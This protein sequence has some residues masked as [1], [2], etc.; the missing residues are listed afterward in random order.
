MANHAIKGRGKSEA[1]LREVP[2]LTKHPAE[3]KEVTFRN[4]NNQ[5]GPSLR[6]EVLPK[7]TS[8]TAGHSL[9]FSAVESDADGVRVFSAASTSRADV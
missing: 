5:E 4:E 2:R 1:S 6:L 9:Q 7:S 3:P 8:L